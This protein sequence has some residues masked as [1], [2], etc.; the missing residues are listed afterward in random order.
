MAL[1]PALAGFFPWALVDISAVVCERGGGV[2]LV[3]GSLHVC[4]SLRSQSS[5]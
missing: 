1:R 5:R 4:S 2:S 3:G